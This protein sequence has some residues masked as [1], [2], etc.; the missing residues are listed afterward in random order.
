MFVGLKYPP[1][2]RALWTV[3]LAYLAAVAFGV[4]GGPTGFA[5][6]WPLASLPPA[7]VIFWY[8]R[9]DFSKNWYDDPDT[10]P[11]GVNTIDDDWKSGLTKLIALLVAGALLSAARH[12]L[13]H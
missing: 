3:G 5:F 6:V 9:R 10:M 13:R 11:E 8:W 4:S 1:N 2:K 7:L 12:F